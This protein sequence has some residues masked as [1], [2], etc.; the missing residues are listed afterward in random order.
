MSGLP[1]ETLLQIWSLADVDG[2]GVLDLRE[3]LLCCWLVQRTVQKQLPPPA[4]LPAQLLESA[5]A[6]VAAKQASAVVQ[7]PRTPAATSSAEEEEDV[8]DGASEFGTPSEMGGEGKKSR[9]GKLLSGAKGAMSGAKK[10]AG[11]LLRS[12][13]KGKAGEDQEAGD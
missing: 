9:R 10:G 12:G 7:A 1:T 3:Y 6:A 13:R 8:D 2:D 11:K 5:T 4:S